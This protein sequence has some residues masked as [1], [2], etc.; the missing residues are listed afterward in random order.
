MEEPPEHHRFLVQA[1]V[2]PADVDGLAVVTVGTAIFG[3]VSVVFAFA[4]NWLTAR[5][6]TSWMQ[7]SVAGFVLGLIGLVYCWRRRRRRRT[8]N[9]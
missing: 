3:L 9:Q 7:I 5:D 2:P 6:H 4:Y 1:P 8:G